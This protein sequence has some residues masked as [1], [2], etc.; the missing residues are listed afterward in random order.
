MK[1]YIGTCVTCN[2]EIYC[3][4]GFLDG[5]NERGRLYCFTCSEERQQETEHNKN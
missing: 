5:V 1:V 2:K 4:D 3:K